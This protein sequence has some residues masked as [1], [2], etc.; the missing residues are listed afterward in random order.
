MYVHRCGAQWW[1]YAPVKEEGRSEPGLHHPSR[2]PLRDQ[3]DGGSSGPSGP[4][5]CG[6][7][8]HFTMAADHQAAKRPLAA[9]VEAFLTIPHWAGYESGG[10]VST[11]HARDSLLLVFRTSAGRSPYPRACPSR[12]P[13][14]GTAFQ[15]A[16]DFGAP[17][18]NRTWNLGLRR[19]AL[20]PLS[21][22]N[23]AS[24]IYRPAGAGFG[25]GASTGL[26]RPGRILPGSPPGR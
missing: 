19:A 17:P 16:P 21:Q 25:P 8:P 20:Y 4:N 7:L 24:G 3:V 2:C 10:V 22:W 15:A 14:E 18:R 9:G 12:N 1:R 13:V 6:L 5:A 11:G 26:R 23:N